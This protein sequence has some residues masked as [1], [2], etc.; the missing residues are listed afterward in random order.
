MSL[1]DLNGSVESEVSMN[2][3]DMNPLDVNVS[4]VIFTLLGDQYLRLIR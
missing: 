2:S 3:A 4:K 1:K